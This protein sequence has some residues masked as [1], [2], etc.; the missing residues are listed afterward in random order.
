MKEGDFE[1]TVLFAD[2][3]KIREVYE[4]HDGY[5]DCLVVIVMI[6]Y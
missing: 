2:N 1:F 6:L 4:V 5:V 3:D